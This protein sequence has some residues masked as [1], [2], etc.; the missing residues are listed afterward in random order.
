MPYETSNNAEKRPV[1]RTIRKNDQF[2][3]KQL[4][5]RQGGE[6]RRTE[7]GGLRGGKNV[8][9]KPAVWAKVRHPEQLGRGKNLTITKVHP[10][11]GEKREGKGV[12]PLTERGKGRHISRW[13]DAKKEGLH[14][15]PPQ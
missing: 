2:S 3:Q 4:T 9:R 12:E 10:S 7:V 1:S 11:L 8:F 13:G 6:F 15:G 14:G 5:A